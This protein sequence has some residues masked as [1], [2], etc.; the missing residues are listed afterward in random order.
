MT[1]SS[2]TPNAAAQTYSNNLDALKKMA[3]KQLLIA[4][5]MIVGLVVV[6]SVLI[7]AS[8]NTEEDTETETE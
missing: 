6:G 1:N 4:T 8:G 7:V 2:V 5:G 3:R